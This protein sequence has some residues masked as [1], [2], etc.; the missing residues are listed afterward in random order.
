[1]KCGKTFAPGEICVA[2]Y[3]EY[4][5]DGKDIRYTCQFGGSCEHQVPDKPAPSPEPAPAKQLWI[6]PDASTC[7]TGGCAIH[8]KPHKFTENCGHALNCPACTPCIPVP[9]SPQAGCADCVC[10]PDAQKCGHRGTC[11]RSPVLFDHYYP[12][13]RVTP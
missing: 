4:A 1:M 7:N 10:G 2:R 5:S 12:I 13:R 3:A 6:C 11:K 8:S 9:P